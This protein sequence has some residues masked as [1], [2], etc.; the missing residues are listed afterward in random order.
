M[1][2]GVPKGYEALLVPFKLVY[3]LVLA[4]FA[5][6]EFVI[7]VPCNEYLGTEREPERFRFSTVGYVAAVVI[8][9]PWLGFVVCTLILFPSKFLLMLA[10]DWILNV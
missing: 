7:K 9:P 8:A 4:L 10:I 6:V 5:A 2:I 1:G 3:L